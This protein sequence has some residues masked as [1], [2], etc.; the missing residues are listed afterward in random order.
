MVAVSEK[1]VNQNQLSV[2]WIIW[3]AMAASLCIYVLICHLMGDGIRQSVGFDFPLDL[4]R[5]ILYGV[6]F[7]T[8]FLTH[9]LRRFILAAK[10]R[11]S[12]SMSSKI[13]PLKYPPPVIGKYTSAMLLS[14]ALSES[15]GIYGLVLF[16]LGDSFQA[17]YIFIGISALGIF[18]YRPKQHEIENLVV[19]MQ[20]KG[21]QVPEP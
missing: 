8:L 15:I 5:N 9:F 12:V 6:G 14:L 11:G 16:F 4:L 10:S 21:A 19:V 20:T 2:L 17:L 3:G 7:F 13:P 18:H 1:G